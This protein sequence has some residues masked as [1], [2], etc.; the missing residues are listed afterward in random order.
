MSQSAT[1]RSLQQRITSM[2]P[3]RIDS[4]L[5]TPKE[6]HSLLPGGMLRK[7]APTAVEGSLQLALA[8]L[9]EVSASGAW[10]GII[11]V[12]QLGFEAV[13]QSGLTLER[14]VLIP[15]PGKHAI[16]ITGMLSEVLT[17]LVLCPSTQPTPG[18][19]ER[20]NAR[21]RDHGTALVIAGAWPRSDTA[22]QVT[23]SR[24]SGLEAGH[25]L[26]RTHELSVSSTDRRGR[27]T[28]TVRFCDGQLT[29]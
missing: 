25:G 29:T 17:A 1:V 9:S 8:L 11:G 5:P 3:A 6:L 12:P 15:N 24:W 2:Q 21:L 16:G 19:V 27:R 14:L 22:L 7:G 10:C 20:L 23:S 28:H 26:L 13:A 4:G 18:E